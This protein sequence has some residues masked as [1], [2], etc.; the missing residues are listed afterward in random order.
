MPD[1]SGPRSQADALFRRTWPVLAEA[2]VREFGLAEQE[3][4]ELEQTVHR[5]FDRFVRRPGDI[6]VLG[7]RY[8][9]LLGACQL[10]RG[11]RLMRAETKSGLSHEF[12]I[13]FPYREPI[14]LASEIEHRLL[15][16]E[17]ESR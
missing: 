4:E 15:D 7:L 10:A 12:E 6:P 9:L 11:I 13:T 1:H 3:A 2:L 16:R 17:K 8:Q 14:E 5:W